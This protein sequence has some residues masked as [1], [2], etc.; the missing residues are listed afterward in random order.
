LKNGGV[1]SVTNKLYYL[2]SGNLIT[3][4]VPD[5]VATNQNDGKDHQLAK[6]I[7]ILDLTY[8]F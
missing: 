4:V 7:E 2:P 6:G 1:I 8:S 5:V 3:G